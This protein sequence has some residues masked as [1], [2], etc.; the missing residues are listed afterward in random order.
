MAEKRLHE[1][2]GKEFWFPG[3]RWRHELKDGVYLCTGK[4]PRD[5]P[6][7]VRDVQPREVEVPKRSRKKTF[8][9]TAYQREYMRKTRAEKKKA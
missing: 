2:C 8:D 7:E 6:V 1:E 9:R 3:E 4:P 5:V